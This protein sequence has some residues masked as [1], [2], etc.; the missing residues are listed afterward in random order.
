M[1]VFKLMVTFNKIVRLTLT[2]R[3]A[4]LDR[5]TR[6]SK[7]ETFCNLVVAK[8]SHSLRVIDLVANGKAKVMSILDN[9]SQIVSVS[10]RVADQLKIPYYSS[11]KID[12]EAANKTIERSLGLAQNVPCQVG[13]IT[14]YL[15]MHVIR[16]PA[17]NILLGRPFD[18]LTQSIIHNFEDGNQMI[19]I[20]D[21]NT[22]KVEMIPTKTRE[23]P[24]YSSKGFR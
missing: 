19:E 11:F 18:C 20:H 1:P 2:L 12:M 16:N 9:G 21:P 3:L 23:K 5:Q 10:K 6:L 14:L 22:D 17:Y 24:Q 8:E 4:G 13:D 7:T 15:Q